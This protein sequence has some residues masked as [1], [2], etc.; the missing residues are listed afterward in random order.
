[1][2]LWSGSGV[3][4]ARRWGEK[5]G[6]KPDHIYIKEKRDDVDL[7]FDDCEVDLAKVNIKVKRVMNSISRS[8]W[9]KTKR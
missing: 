5:L 7:C 4:W 9:N 6:L 3:D 8:E 2:V 1:M